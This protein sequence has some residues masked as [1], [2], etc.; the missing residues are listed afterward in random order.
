MKNN[1]PN[2]TLGIYIFSS[3][4]EISPNGHPKLQNLSRVSKLEFYS[5]MPEL[6]STNFYDSLKIRMMKSHSKF[7]K[8]SFSNTK[9]IY[10]ICDLNATIPTLLCKLILPQMLSRKRGIVKKI[11]FMGSSI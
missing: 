6:L 7:T 10:R 9:I 8:K 3:K 11:Y 5:I 2:L 4:S 1:S